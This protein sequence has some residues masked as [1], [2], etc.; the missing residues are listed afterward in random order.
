MQI[1][2]EA[3]TLAFLRTYGLSEDGPSARQARREAKILKDRM[4]RRR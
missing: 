2:S 3:L 1:V 4:R